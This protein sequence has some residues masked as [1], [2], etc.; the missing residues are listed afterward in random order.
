[1]RV[2]TKKKDLQ[3]LIH[4]FSLCIGLGME[5]GGENGSGAEQRIE[6]LP[7]VGNELTEWLWVHA[8]RTMGQHGLSHLLK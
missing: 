1:M 6:N 4:H 7:E 5:A 2:G 8:D 3:L